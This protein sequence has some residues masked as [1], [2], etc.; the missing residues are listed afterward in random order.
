MI[1]LKVHDG[2]IE[3]EK[4]PDRKVVSMNGAAHI[5]LTGNAG[6]S[7]G[8]ALAHGL[9][10]QCNI[11]QDGIGKSGGGGTI[12]ISP[13][14]P[15]GHPCPDKYLENC[16]VGGNAV[17]YGN[18]GT[19]IFAKGQL[20][21]RAGVCMK[22][23]AIVCEGCKDYGA[24]FMTN[25]TFISLGKVGNFFGNE[26]SGGLSILY[27]PDRSVRNGK[28]SSMHLREM[29][30][31]E[32]HWAIQGALKKM[33]QAHFDHTGSSKAQKI[34]ANWEVE[35]DNFAYLI[36]RAYDR[37]QTQEAVDVMNAVD[38]DRKTP[39]SPGESATR[40]NMQLS[41]IRTEIKEAE[42]LSGHLT[43]ANLVRDTYGEKFDI[44]SRGIS[45]IDQQLKPYL[46]KRDS[47]TIGEV[48]DAIQAKI[49]AK[50]RP[51][52]VQLMEARDKANLN[53]IVMSA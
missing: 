15:E 12:V 13:E 25:G 46:G 11:A 52:Y 16:V 34:L 41:A 9:L 33:V 39:L 35:K 26:Q 37:F 32:G 36:P 18:Q 27:D 1:C 51:G 19:Y 20:G 2:R 43:T 40:L 31:D 44:D 8:F 3:M 5:K 21:T 24:E 42:L 45:I 14:I 49:D 47:M 10:L 17:A 23:G 29:N 4:Y 53:D 30:N 50:Q 48:I 38:R 22:G 7:F 6:Q 28:V